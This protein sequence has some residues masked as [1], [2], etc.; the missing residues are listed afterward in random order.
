MYV[1]FFDNSLAKIYHMTSPRHKKVKKSNP[2]VFLGGKE[3][4]PFASW[5]YVG[6]GIAERW[7]QGV[8]GL[9]KLAYI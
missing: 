9:N 3:L 7:R 8:S 6:V 2:T 1:T 4:E 5:P